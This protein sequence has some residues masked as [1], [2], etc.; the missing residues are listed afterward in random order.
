MQIFT[1]S[2]WNE[3]ELILTGQ[4]AIHCARVLR[5]KPGDH[6]HCIDGQGNWFKATLTTINKHECRANILQH[7]FE[8]WEHKIRIHIAISLLKQAA[9]FEHFVEKAVEMG[10]YEITP[11]ICK[12]TERMKWRKDR[13]EKIAIAACKQSMRAQFPIINDAVPFE[14]KV[15]Q[16][17]AEKY[18]R[19]IAYVD[20]KKAYFEDVYKPGQNAIILIGPEGGFS[21]EEIHLAQLHAWQ[22]VS[23]GEQ[24]LRTETAGMV[25]CQTM[26]AINRYVKNER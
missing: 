8:D 5:K 3:N 18:Q 24:R 11:L 10:V 26:N 19:M 23:L 16:K 25:A 20:E 1:C 15:Q 22:A 14:Q 21:A 13:M 9:R 2:S 7:R 4:E 12:R 17:S 6:I